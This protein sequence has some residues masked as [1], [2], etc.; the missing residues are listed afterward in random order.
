MSNIN[1]MVFG[2]CVCLV[3][4][5]ERVK[6]VFD[7]EVR[8]LLRF[9]SREGHSRNQCAMVSSELLQN[10]HLA[11]HDRLIFWLYVLVSL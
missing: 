8:Y 9:A 6:S 3:R 2:R 7:L 1:L 4:I 11:V 5:W 10:L